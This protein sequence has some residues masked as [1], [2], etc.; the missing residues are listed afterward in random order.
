MSLNDPRWG[1]SNDEQNRQEPAQPERPADERQE[2]EAPRNDKTP[3]NQQNGAD[4]NRQ[5]TNGRKDDNDLDQLWGDFN[6]AINDLLGG[7]NNAAKKNRQQDDRNEA[8][9][10]GQSA[11][12]DAQGS[13]DEPRQQPDP[14]MDALRGGPRG[15]PVFGGAGPSLKG[16]GFLGAILAIGWAAT[17]FYIV[18][19]GQIGVVTTFGRYT[20]DTTAGFSWRMPWPIQNVEI[21]DVSSVRKSEIGLRGGESRLREALMLTDDENIVDVQFNVQYRI[22]PHGAKD[23]LFMT[24]DPDMTVTQVA[25]SAMREVVGR[26]TMDSVLFESKQ[27]IALSVKQAMQ[28]MLD[29]YHTGIEVMSVA[30]QNA[31]PP[32]QVQA[33]FNDAVKAGQDRERQINEGEAYANAV[34]PKAKGLASRLTQEAEGYKARVVETATGDAERF[35]KVLEQYEKAPTVTRD[36]MYI[37]TLRDVYASTNKV[38]VDSKSGNNLLYLPL[39]KLIEKSAVAAPAPAVSADAGAQQAVT[40]PAPVAE[41]A[42]ELDARTL[43]RMRGR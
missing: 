15:K 12:T 6:N 36:R 9:E 3:D 38:L 34:I 30:I 35:E 33:A 8:F 7:L 2:N 25:E 17:G 26:K 28:S 14:L 22:K 19:E 41:P 39:D 23:F 31:Q 27:E 13:Q 20:N 4:R 5:N 43:M 11:N 32:E 24:R 42:A 18:P 40:Q 16:L 1:R 21:V 37:D 29:R 10:R